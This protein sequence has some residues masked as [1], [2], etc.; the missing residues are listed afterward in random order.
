MGPSF[1]WGRPNHHG[2]HDVRRSANSPLVFA[3]SQKMA[4][5]PESMLGQQYKE[6]VALMSRAM[7]L[8]KQAGETDEARR[9]TL[10]CHS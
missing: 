6:A 3:A 1:C 9:I 4:F 5:A 2:T 10:P 7:H 8:L